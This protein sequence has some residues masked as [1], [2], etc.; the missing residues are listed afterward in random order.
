V[1]GKK[2][3]LKGEKKEVTCFEKINYENFSSSWN[4]FLKE[5]SDMSFWRERGLK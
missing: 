1:P 3:T 4:D 5:F 2:T